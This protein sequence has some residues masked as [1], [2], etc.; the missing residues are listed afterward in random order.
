MPSLNEVVF[1]VYNNLRGGHG[2]NN[3]L[4]SLRQ[5]KRWVLNYRSMIIRQAVDKGDIPNHFEQE[6]DNVPFEVV[7][8]PDGGRFGMDPLDNKM[9]FR[10][11]IQI[12]EPVRLKSGL[13]AFTFI[14]ST[15][16]INNYEL[17]DYHEIQYKNTYA[18]YTGNSPKATW[19]NNQIYITNII[20]K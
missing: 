5:I 19:F 12:P 3:T 17:V 4:P 18:R 2:E 15:D 7:E 14:G 11:V 10:S 6:M 8:Y 13:P 20:I 1:D 9:L 16:L